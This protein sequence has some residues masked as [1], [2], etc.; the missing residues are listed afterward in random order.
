MIT[1][2][3]LKE[4]TTKKPIKVFVK[5]TLMPNGELNF[6]G[7]YIYLKPEDKVYVSK[8]DDKNI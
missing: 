7:F 5:G 2:K 4:R 3:E 8:S 6:K 1:I